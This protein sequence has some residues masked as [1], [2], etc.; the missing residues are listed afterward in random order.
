MPWPGGWAAIVAI[1]A[2]QESGSDWA[3]SGLS[4]TFLIA[5]LLRRRWGE[6][7]R[8]SRAVAVL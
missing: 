1:D 3:A 7:D 2:E 4:A 5:G 6:T 8:V